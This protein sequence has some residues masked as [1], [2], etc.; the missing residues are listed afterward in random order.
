MFQY[1]TFSGLP[2]LTGLFGCRSRFM[3]QECGGPKAFW[4]PIL[5]NDVPPGG[6]ASTPKLLAANRARAPGW[7]N[8]NFLSTTIHND[9]RLLGPA[10]VF[11][12]AYK[13]T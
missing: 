6:T 7:A 11:F 2:F 8:L 9:S 10:A 5:T 1:S 4:Y 12:L 13:C 3:G